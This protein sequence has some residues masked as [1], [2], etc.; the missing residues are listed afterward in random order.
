MNIVSFKFL[1]LVHFQNITFIIIFW[2]IFLDCHNII[3]GLHESYNRAPCLCHTINICFLKLNPAKRV[4]QLVF[5][6]VLR[7][8]IYQYFLGHILY[9]TAKIGACFLLNN[10]MECVILLTAYRHI[11][12]NCLSWENLLLN[13]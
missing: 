11:L 3:I 5:I 4:P 10:F 7:P 2:C 1:I 9:D 6:I 12:A 13:W 8:I